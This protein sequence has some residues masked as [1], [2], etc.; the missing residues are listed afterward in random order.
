M[1]TSEDIMKKHYGMIGLRKLLA[2]ED[3]PP[4]QE[5]IDAGIVPYFMQLA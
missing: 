4:I 1:A 2:V 3:N 5:V